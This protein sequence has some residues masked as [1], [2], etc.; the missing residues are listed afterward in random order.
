[1]KRQIILLLFCLYVVI[2]QGCKKQA[3]VANSVVSNDISFENPSYFPTTTTYDFQQNPVNT[4]TF[5]L[6][7]ALFYD[8]ILSRNG[9]ISC[10]SCHLQ[11]QAFVQVDHAFSHGI[12][13]HLTARNTPALQN[14]A[15]SPYFFW[16]GG[17]PSLYRTSMSPLENP[18]EMDEK[19]ANVLVKL[20]NHP[21][22]P[23]RFA[24]A[25]GDTAITQDR[26]LKA[27]AQFMVMLVSANSK[28]DQ[29]V[30]KKNISFTQDEQ[31]GYSLFQQKCVN[32]HPE[33]L[34]TDHKFRNNGIQNEPFADIGR[35]EASAVEPRD[36]GLFKTPSLRNVALTYPYMHNGSITTLEKVIEHYNS[37][38][39]NSSTLDVE[40]KKQIPV[41]IRIN[42]EEKRKLVAFLNTLTDD[43]FIRDK[44]FSE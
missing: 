23:S 2:I 9:K 36:V 28:Y 27:L 22:Y 14:L 31:D 38:V 12:D 25:F 43:T 34:F 1:M 13:D 18:L 42:A 16:V 10:G 19:I 20:K 33:P 7:K 21:N 29:V 32:C 4:A 37:G 15:W 11:A 3:E 8:G 30:Y 44:R 5:E 41:G 39:I 35:A 26:F 40:F 6:G 24:K 17:V